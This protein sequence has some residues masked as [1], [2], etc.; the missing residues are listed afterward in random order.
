MLCARKEDGLI[1]FGRQ[2]FFSLAVIVD[3]AIF[4]TSLQAFV[5]Q[6]ILIFLLYKIPYLKNERIGHL[7]EF[8][9]VGNGTRVVAAVHILAEL[10]LFENVVK[11]LHLIDGWVI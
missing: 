5:R 10:L 11:H 2:A 8:C 3:Y 6:Q 1:A 7:A 9:H 4:L